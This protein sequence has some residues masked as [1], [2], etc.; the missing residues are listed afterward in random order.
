V[1]DTEVKKACE[2]VR[3]ALEN[4]RLEFPSRRITVNLAPAGLPKKS[5]RFDLADRAR[6]PRCQRPG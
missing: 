5:G 4:C 3:A 6:H 2:H 1:P